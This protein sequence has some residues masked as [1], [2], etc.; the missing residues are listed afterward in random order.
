MVKT[1]RVLSAPTSPG[2]P[3]LL[4][5]LVVGILALELGV[6]A[7]TRAG[8]QVMPL[9]W[10]GLASS[11]L[12]LSGLGKFRFL[13]RILRPAAPRSGH[14]DDEAI[15]AAFNA[16]KP[17]AEVLDA[18]TTFPEFLYGAQKAS[19][20]IFPSGTT[21]LAARFETPEAA[22]AAAE[23][24]REFFGMTQLQGSIH[25]TWSGARAQTR[26]HAS[27]RCQGNLLLAC[28]TR[29]RSQL[30]PRLVLSIASNASAVRF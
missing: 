21:F 8:I 30:D 26:D 6:S 10:V 13:S 19:L 27:V 2:W 11:V 22:L 29:E 23:G 18:R 28:S 25:G 3:I 9:A 14:H 1:A 16:W 17:N 7:S 12:A 5:F 20:A 24:Y 15:D 4:A